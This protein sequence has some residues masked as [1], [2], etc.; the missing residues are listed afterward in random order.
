M[1]FIKETTQ[2]GARK[3]V[4]T[5]KDLDGTNSPGWAVSRPDWPV[6]GS[7]VTTVAPDGILMQGR[8]L[9]TPNRPPEVAVMVVWF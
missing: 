2:I 6:L 1:D 8:W 5:R 9:P 3:P 7:E 4:L